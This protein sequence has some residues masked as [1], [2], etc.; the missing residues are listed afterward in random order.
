M[1][2]RRVRALGP[3]ARALLVGSWSLSAVG[4]DQSPPRHF[5]VDVFI[6]M[7]EI[8]ELGG[9]ASHL[10]E[11][12]DQ[13]IGY[14]TGEDHRLD[15][16]TV[17]LFPIYDF[18]SS[19]PTIASIGPGSRNDNR[20]NRLDEISKFRSEVETGIQELL[21]RF[22]DFETSSGSTYLESYILEPVCRRLRHVADPNTDW[23][24]IIFSDML[25]KSTL[26]SF[27]DE[28]RTDGEM[29]EVLEGHCLPDK[30]LPR[31]CLQI[32]YQ[33][34][35][36][37]DRKVLRARRIWGEFFRGRACRKYAAMASP[38]S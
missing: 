1:T 16:G 33:P 9:D 2:R 28:S 8:E 10:E 22:A 26:F 37:N 12:L 4:C 32:V 38:A 34:L 35:K 25:E 27:Y 30:L 13:I 14:V 21:S 29:L 15:Y 24:V 20:L 19:T 3:V 23:H 7:T 5:L 36:A 11:S 31:V 17:T 6:D 18:A